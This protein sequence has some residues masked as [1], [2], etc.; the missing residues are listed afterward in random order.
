MA[1][2]KSKWVC[3]VCEYETAS[4]IG[5]CPECDEW[6]SFKEEVITKS[7]SK[8]SALI[9]DFDSY[10]E[11]QLLNDIAMIDE[12]FFSTGLSEFDRVLGR[13]IVQNSL[14]LLGGDPGIGK[15][16]ILLQVCGQLSLAG[17]KTLYI[18]AEESPK[19][20]KLRSERL[21]INADNL[22]IFANM[23]LS[24]IIDEARKLEPMVV[25]VD[26]IQ[27]IHDPNLSSAP[28]SISQIRECCNTLFN[29]AKYGVSSVFM[30]GHVTKEGAIAGPKVL[31]HVVDTVLYLEGDSFKTYRILRTVKNRFGSTNEIGVFNMC[32]KGMEEVLNPSELFLTQRSEATAPGSV[33]IS[34]MEGTR[35]MLVEVQALVGPTTYASPRRIATGLE[36]NRLQQILAVLE[37]RVGISLSKHDVYA[38]LVGGISIS[39]P[40]ADLGIALAIVSS[41]R[42]VVVDKYTAIVGEI[43]LTGEIR[44]VN[45]VE[46]RINEA[47]KQ[48]FKRIIIPQPNYSDDLIM[49]DI[50]VIGVNRLI[51]AISK[52]IIVN[53]EE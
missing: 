5:K 35:A 45:K 9:D 4:Y 28:G 50:E 33:V 49:P 43:G 36:Y 1:K 24:R 22:Y 16:T 17:I 32:D 42:N 12:V 8:N 19:Q 15:S 44:P 51:E 40:S 7:S 21:G 20:L 37:R 38:S 47:R 41:V 46:I 6:S 34:I 10:M 2:Y 3:Q 39:E 31:E 13:G 52:S 27:A 53:K 29:F 14:V 11:P 26:S 18:S 30:I 25:I 48:G 23:N